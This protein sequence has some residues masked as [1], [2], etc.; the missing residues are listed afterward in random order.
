[1]DA[2]R[3]Y[4]FE[5]ETVRGG[6][7]GPYADTVDEFI[8]R[9]KNEKE[10]SEFIIE[11]FCKGFIAKPVRFKDSPCWADSK[12]EFGKI[13]DREYKYKRTIPSTH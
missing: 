10:H 8:I 2:I 9:D 6:Q 3:T 7:I 13:G 4:F 12:E 11:K 5:V 1:M